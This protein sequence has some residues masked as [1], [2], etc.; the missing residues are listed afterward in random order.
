MFDEETGRPTRESDRLE[1]LQRIEECEKTGQIWLDLG[2]L[3]LEELP[4][5]LGRLSHLRHLALGVCSFKAADGD[6]VIWEYDRRRRSAQPLTNLSSLAGLGALTTLSLAGCERVSDLGP[7]GAL[8]GLVRLDFEGC[9]SVSDLRP[10]R[11][12]TGV[13]QLSLRD[14]AL[15][16]H[17]GSLQTLTSL[18]TLHLGECASVSDLGPLQALTGLVRLDLN[19]CKSVSDLGPLQALTGLV[20]LD[21]NGC[22]S[23]SDVGP[24]RTLTGLTELSMGD[25]ALVSDLG[26]L[27]TL[28]GLTSLNL[29]SCSSV[30]DLGSLETLT[31]LTWLDLSW[32]TAV[33][34]LGPLSTLTGLD[35]L[36]LMEC[37]SVSDLGPLRTLSGLTGLCLDGCRLVWDLSPL[38]DL[39]K[40]EFLSI[41]ETGVSLPDH[42]SKSSDAPAILASYRENKHAGGKKPLREVKLLLVGQ[43]RVGKTHLRLRFFEQEDIDH[44]DPTL[45]ST[46]HIDYTEGARHQSEDQWKGHRSEVPLIKLRVWDFGGQNEL[47]SSHRFF[48]GSQRCFYILVLAADRPANGESR[49]SN[50]LNYWLRV[51]AQY[52]RRGEGNRA[53]VLIVVTRSDVER[54]KSYREEI[55]DALEAARKYEWFG[56]HVVE[57][58]RGLGWSSGLSKTTHKAV[59]ERHEAAAEVM[60]SAIRNHLGAVIDLDQEISPVYHAAKAFVQQAF[61]KERVGDETNLRT[62]LAGDDLKRFAELFE[63]SEA[64]T[65]EEEREGLRR[66][67]LGLLNS[68]GVVHWIGDVPEIDRQNPWNLRDIAFN[69]EWVRRPVYDLIR[70]RDTDPDRAGFLNDQQ[71]RVLLAEREAGNPKSKEL[72]EQLPFGR[73]DRAR[74]LELMKACRLVFDHGAGGGLLVPDLLSATS[75]ADENSPAGTW[76][77][78]AEFLPEKVFLRFIARHYDAIDHHADRCFRNRVVWQTEGESVFLE[79][80]YSPPGATLPHILIGSATNQPLSKMVAPT[81]K[82]LFDE[83]YKEERLGHVRRELTEGGKPA[84]L[85]ATGRFV[86]RC[87]MMEL[88]ATRNRPAKSVPE[89]TIVW[90]GVDLGSTWSSLKGLGYLHRLIRQPGKLIPVGEFSRTERSDAAKRY[91]FRK[92]GASRPRKKLDDDLETVMA[93]NASESVPRRSSKFAEYSTKKLKQLREAAEFKQL[94]APDSKTKETCRQQVEELTEEIDRRSNPELKRAMRS[95]QAELRKAVDELKTRMKDKGIP[96]QH[97]GHFDG[98]ASSAGHELHF[99]YEKPQDIAWDTD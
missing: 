21:L 53:P 77:Y 49:D 5:A 34:D 45:E 79:A 86:F 51:I 97:W 98:C 18:K 60:N 95:V 89:F 48:L 68:L 54:A 90:G 87:E 8:T 22:K 70:C 3:A 25:C 66:D 63:R 82:T 52:G 7:L 59:W 88:P 46:K 69:P 37:T 44:H 26:P 36:E 80:H 94:Q 96:E 32:C 58:V 30:S 57:V 42:L 9:K 31:G 13:T 85:R 17:L 28:T 2:D 78:T 75:L 16:S 10:L 20:R 64:Q 99:K 67:C 27:S 76:M 1:A 47:H 62:C 12:L 39:S 23:V 50:R 84:R 74:I 43:G 92:K 11:T 41:K 38:L 35:S 4:R 15:V 93:G 83:I 14:C 19:G 61:S 55:D 33:S 6:E 56:A 73:E 24:L 81:V 40:L 29:N 65:S 71:V 91:K 72:Y